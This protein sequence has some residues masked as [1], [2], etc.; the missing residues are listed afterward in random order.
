MNKTTDIEHQGVVIRIEAGTAVVRIV[1]NS[2]CA[3]CHAKG[4]CSAAD[5]AEK[6]ITVPLP[7]GRAIEVG[8]EVWLVGRSSK[9]LQ[10]VL[11]AYI[12][13]LVLLMAV[14]LLVQYYMKSET[15]AAAA[16]VAS[17][18]PYY[19]MLYLFRKRLTK[20]FLF[21]INIDKK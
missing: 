19:G 7:E 6:D 5:K 12:F 21:F 16:A 18:I 17:L 8:Q 1:Q 2:A 4:A 11:Y 14:L 3:A 20:K 13:P 15:I 9:G 10:A